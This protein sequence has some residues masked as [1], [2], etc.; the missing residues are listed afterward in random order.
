VAIARELAL[1]IVR[2]GVGEALGDLHRFDPG[3]Y[4]RA[5]AGV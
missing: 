5:I 1:P 4:A 3:E 2:I